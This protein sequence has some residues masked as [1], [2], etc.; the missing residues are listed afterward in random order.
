MF[1]TAYKTL[2]PGRMRHALRR[3]FDRT[4]CKDYA[5]KETLGRRCPWTILTRH[6]NP[7]SVVYSGGV[8]EDISFELELIDRFGLS[9]HVFDPSPMALDTLAGVS[10]Q[11]D[12]LLFKPLG[13]AGS[14]MT[15]GFAPLGDGGNGLPH[16]GKPSGSRDTVSLLCTTLAEE[17]KA[18]G[19]SRIDL[20]KIDIEG[21]EY[22]VL[23][24]CLAGGVLPSQICV[25][26][27]HFMEDMPSRA[28]TASLLWRLRRNGYDLIHKHQYDYTL[29]LRM[30]L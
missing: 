16:W 27:H 26:F 7:G 21:F 17:M 5:D 11:R 6:L 25:E 13:L 9:V 14:A 30:Q 3:S 8:G 2:V 20:L 15:M 1:G 10:G 19:H 23:E 24:S 28:G 29:Y 22:E 4:F 18:N 12:K